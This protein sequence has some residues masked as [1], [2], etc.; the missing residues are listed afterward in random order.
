MQHASGQQKCNMR[1]VNM[2]ISLAFLAPDPSALDGRIAVRAFGEVSAVLGVL[3][4]YFGLFHA[5]P[6]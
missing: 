5:A 4:K 3:P 6:T 1:Q 2:T